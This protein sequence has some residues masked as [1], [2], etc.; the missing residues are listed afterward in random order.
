MESMGGPS[1]LREKGESGSW[2]SRGGFPLAGLLKSAG[3]SCPWGGGWREV[4]FLLPEGKWGL[5]PSRRCR[6][7]SLPV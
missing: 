5:L 3:L 1:F 2:R 4:P 7:R 6:Q